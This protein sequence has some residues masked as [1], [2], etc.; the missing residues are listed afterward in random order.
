MFVVEGHVSLKR[1]RPVSYGIEEESLQ[2]KDII[3]EVVHIPD[4]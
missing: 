1:K 4:E 2:K 3:E